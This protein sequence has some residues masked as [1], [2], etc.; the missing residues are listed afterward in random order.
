MVMQKRDE[1]SSIIESSRH[2]ILSALDVFFRKTP[3][4]V[5]KSEDDKEISP[6]DSKKLIEALRAVFQ[7]LAQENTKRAEESRASPR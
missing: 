1:E 7:T 6:Q 5:V 2:S 3:E 4:M